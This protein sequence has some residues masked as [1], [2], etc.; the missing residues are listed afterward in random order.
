MKGS[1]SKQMYLISFLTIIEIN[2]IKS[3]LIQII[4]N[5]S[6]KIDRNIINSI[7]F[8]DADSDD[9]RIIAEYQRRLRRRSGILRDRS[10]PQD[11]I[12]TSAKRNSVRDSISQDSVSQVHH[13]PLYSFKNSS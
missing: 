1:K 10:N 3:E 8:A 4:N 2:K 13:F 12:R 5:I 9:D 6:L 11:L 7:I